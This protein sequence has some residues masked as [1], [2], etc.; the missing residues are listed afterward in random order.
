MNKNILLLLPFFLLVGAC[1]S[2]APKSE[3]LPQVS[4][5]PLKDVVPCE[6]GPKVI[7]IVANKGQFSVAPPH[8][9]VGPNDNIKV[10]FT[11]NNDAGIITLKAKFFID[12]PWLT[13]TNPA[14]NP[15]QAIITVP[16]DADLSTYFYTIT[17]VGFG[18]IDPM[19]TVDD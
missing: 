2:L 14:G 13:A 4:L 9:C 16:A 7:T 15:Q 8:L 11:G 1:E 19:I 10:I 12:A 18:T 5:P 6:N 17:A 3:P